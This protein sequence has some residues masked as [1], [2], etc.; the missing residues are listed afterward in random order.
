MA[1][2]L[3]RRY[4]AM[5]LPFGLDRSLCLCVNQASMDS[6]L[7]SPMPSLAHRRRR[8]KIPFVLAIASGSGQLR[9]PE[10]IDED[11]AGADFRGYFNVAVETLLSE[12]F[13]LISMDARTPFENWGNVQGDDIWCGWMR[14]GIHKADTGYFFRQRGGGSA[15]CIS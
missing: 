4:E 5:D 14:D 12:F 10:D 2:H 8:K 3:S 7:D 6:I 11:A 9:A 15:R 13:V 1:D